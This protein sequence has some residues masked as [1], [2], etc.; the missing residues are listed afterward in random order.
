MHASVGDRIVIQTECLGQSPREGTVQ[1]VLGERTAEHYRVTWDDGHES[2]YFPGPDSRVIP[3]QR[4]PGDADGY[5]GTGVAPAAPEAATEERATGPYDAVER[6]M[7]APMITVEAEETLRNTAG[8]LAE[9]DI[10]AVVVFSSGTPIGIISERDVIRAVAAGGD[11]EEIWAADVIDREMVWASPA[12]STAHVAALM[13]DNG[14]RH[15]PLRDQETVV[16]MVSV[17]DVLNVL[18]GPSPE[19]AEAGDATAATGAT[20]SPEATGAT[21][22]PEATEARSPESGR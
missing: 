7:S 2:V 3:G 12:D 11:P 20:A 22:S 4:G 21:T 13:R 5:A 9:A 15:I 16:G 17:R 6:I 10:G 18:L 14:V 19:A 1:E 8:S